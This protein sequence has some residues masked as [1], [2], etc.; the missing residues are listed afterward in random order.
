[1]IK[2]RERVIRDLANSILDELS[3]YKGITMDFIIYPNKINNHYHMLFTAK[4]I[5]SNRIEN[6]HRTSK[7]IEIT[8]SSE[9][10]MKY[11]IIDLLRKEIEKTFIW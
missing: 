8:L 6:T 10:L 2:V 4:V 5:D 1:M 11:E 9:A 7:S 3:I